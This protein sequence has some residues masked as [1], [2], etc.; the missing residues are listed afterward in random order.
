MDII[1]TLLVGVDGLQYALAHLT[2]LAERGRGRHR[3]T[4]SERGPLKIEERM[5]PPVKRT[6][7]GH[8]FEVRSRDHAG[9][10][11]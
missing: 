5:T 6:R 4:K 1:A 11:A 3:Q 2:A 7:S 10:G 9:L 8:T